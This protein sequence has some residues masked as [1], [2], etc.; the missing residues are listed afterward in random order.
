MQRVF[1]A[2]IVS[3]AVSAMASTPL[4]P[5]P[6]SE[7]APQARRI[8]DVY[9]DP[10]PANPP[11]KLHVV[12][13]TPSDRDPAEQYA[14]RLDKILEDIRA[15]Y[16][17]EMKR[18]GFGPKTFVLPR[19]T[20]GEL[21]IHLVKGK[22]PASAFPR[23]IGRNGGNTGAPEGGD[24]VKRAC[25]RT[26]EAAGIAY[27]R[28]TV[29]IFCHLAAYDEKAGTFRHHSPYFGSWDQESGLCFAADWA[30]Q[31]LDNLTKKSPKLNDGEYGDMS[32]G[33]HTTIFIGGIA[34][35]LGHAFALPHCGERWD[36]KA[37]GTSLLG[38]GNHTY[39]EELRDEGK[40]SF[41]TMASA[42]RLASRPLFNGS[43][44]G[45]TEAPKIEQCKLSLSTNLV[46]ADLAGR[47]GG[48][49]V[50]GTVKGSPPVYA[51]IGYFDSF[52]DGGYRAPSATAV[53]DESGNFAIE[54][55][56][57]AQCA[58]GELRIEFCHANGA[59][60]ERRLGFAVSSEG[61]VDLSQW[62]MRAALEPVADAVVRDDYTGA[63]TAVEQIEKSTASD[64]T[65][66]IARKLAG[67]LSSEPKLI[68]ADV[69]SETAEFALGD[70]RATEAKVGWLKPASNRIPLNS[71]ITSALLDAGKVYATGL[72]GHAPSSY[73][74]DLGGKWKELSG[75]AGLHTLQQP[76][77]SVIFI[78]KADGREIF[79]SA[80]IRGAK[81]A[82][83]NVK[84]EGVQKLELLVDP[85]GNGNG[86]DWGLWLDP[87]LRR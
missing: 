58:N 19:N 65:K 85:A 57:L 22:E 48:L 13:F 38:G 59:V 71:Q 2:F 24:I 76:Y 39:R 84:L 53:P 81:K 73:L 69:A 49:R 50:E 78:I 82:A 72:Y 6:E 52:H 11:K 79:R 75:E 20:Q 77:G 7:Q 70:A 27:E 63:Q 47:R 9:H 86:N 45:M 14:Q 51:V 43:D 83:Y 37:L 32:L 16:G 54:V 34:H 64:L 87:M 68:P 4:T 36:E 35:E 26:V 33:K 23:W 74:F 12:Y 8:L 61:K 28:E 44:K 55:S 18:L 80:T 3:F 31:N 5:I 25:Q 21:V 42:M 10:R 15:F 66:E 67:T 41:L 46:R 56:D 17:D 1:M 29:L 40:G 60:S 62:E 30:N